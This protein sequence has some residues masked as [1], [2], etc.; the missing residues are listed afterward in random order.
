MK[1]RGTQIK[2]KLK[3]YG[4]VHNRW[5]R[6]VDMGDDNLKAEVEQIM[7]EMKAVHLAYI[8]TLPESFG[9]GY[10]FGHF[11]K[12]LANVMTYYTKWNREDIYETKKSLKRVRQYE[13]REGLKPFEKIMEVEK[14][15]TELARLTAQAAG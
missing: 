8:E 5:Q 14:R 10:D 3:L 7:L 1:F 15:A 9:P 11:Q 4:S 13:K 6:A 2:N 12:D